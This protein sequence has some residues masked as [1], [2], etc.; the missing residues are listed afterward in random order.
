LRVAAG[1]IS[2]LST[3]TH[4]SRAYIL[5]STDSAAGS[6]IFTVFV[7]IALPNAQLG[8]ERDGALAPEFG[9]Q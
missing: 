2:S 3:R 7:A 1:R 9:E 5:A 4:S 8:A 6:I